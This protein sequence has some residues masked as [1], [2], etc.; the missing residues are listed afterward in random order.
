MNSNID[1]PSA[2][3]IVEARRGLLVTWV[4]RLQDFS[5]YHDLGPVN[6]VKLVRPPAASIRTPRE[7]RRI[8]TRTSG[9]RWTLVFPREHGAWGMLLVP[10]ATGAAAGLLNGGRLVALLPLVLAALALFWLRTPVET[11][12]G[13]TP[14][15]ARADEE[16]RFVLYTIAVLAAVSVAALAWLF[17]G[18]RNRDVFAIGGGTGLAFL[19]QAVLKKVWRARTGAQ[20]IGAAGLASA[21]PAAY[22]VATGGWA[23]MAAVLWM[24]NWLFAV[25]QIHFVQARIHG[26]R[27][28]DR[29]AKMALGRGFLVGQCVL[30]VALSLAGALRLFPWAASAAF[31]PALARGFVWTAGPPRPLVIRRLGFSELFLSIAF[32]VLL[33][34]GLAGG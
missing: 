19:I 34:W 9:R 10:L 29:R 6:F 21:A 7:K 25:N 14:L 16:R 13:A 20:M 33:V 18:A 26:A 3:R 28:K 32:G 2:L 11:W 12:L 15:R 31:L 17:W 5:N 22:A 24:A 30:M 1:D 4:T 23:R 8:E 27:A